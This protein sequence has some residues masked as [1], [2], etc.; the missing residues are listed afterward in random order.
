MIKQ[1][2]LLLIKWT[3][4][5]IIIFDFESVQLPLTDTVNLLTNVKKLNQ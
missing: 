5:N 2:L 1:A 3:L 4:L